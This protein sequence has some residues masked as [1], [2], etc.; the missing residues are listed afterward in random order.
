MDN[1]V[2]YSPIIF[3][4]IIGFMGAGILLVVLNVMLRKMRD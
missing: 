1:V 2:W 4:V 3:Q